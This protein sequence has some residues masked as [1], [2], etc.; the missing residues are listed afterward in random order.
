[1]WG[2]PGCLRDGEVS[3]NALSTVA[4]KMWASLG[5]PL[6]REVLRNT[7]FDCREDDVKL[8]TLSSGWGSAVK[9]SALLQ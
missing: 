9:Y 3:G 6:C 8:L 1:M 5:G 7:L 2:L 4:R